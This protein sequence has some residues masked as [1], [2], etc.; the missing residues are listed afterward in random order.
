MR[1]KRSAARSTTLFTSDS[2]VTSASMKSAVPPPS[3]ISSTSEWPR[4]APSPATNTLAPASAK[5]SAVARPMPSVAPMT[6]A[7]F[8]EKSVR[9]ENSMKVLAFR[10]RGSGQQRR[11][12]RRE[13]LTH[14]LRL[15][16][17]QNLHRLALDVEEV[18][19]RRD[20]ERRAEPRNRLGH[21]G[22]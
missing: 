4:S 22:L 20:S 3:R 19:A 15:A 6:R 5:A 17:N 1:P 14:G 10:G 7:F 13:Q 18:A 9:P 11:L 2:N 8:P 16:A 12:V 21:A